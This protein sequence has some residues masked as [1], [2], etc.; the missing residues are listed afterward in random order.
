MCSAARFF[1]VATAISLQSGAPTSYAYASQA[2]EIRFHAAQTI[3]SAL[4]GG[5]LNLK[6]LS[7]MLDLSQ[8]TVAVL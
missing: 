2:R 5:D 8:T 6:Q 3:K 4:R 1:G 7:R